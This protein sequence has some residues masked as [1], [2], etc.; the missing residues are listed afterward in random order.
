MEQEEAYVEALQSAVTY[1]VIHD[2]LEID[3]AVGKTILVFAVEAGG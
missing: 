1:R 3:N 2:R